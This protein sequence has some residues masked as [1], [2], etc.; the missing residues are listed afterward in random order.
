MLFPLALLAALHAA[1]AS[2][3]DSVT[4]TWRISG[5][6]V[7][8][9]VNEL[10]TLK[11]AG[12]AV[13]GSCK[14]ADAADAKPY[15]VTGEVKGDTVTFR[16]GGDYQGTAITLTYTGTTATPKA[17]KGTIDVQPFGVNGT[18]SAAPAPAAPAK[19]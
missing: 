7:G 6:V 16:H 13:T 3:A 1:P 19:P 15:D 12:A 11:Q 8:N 10:C 5:D 14:N 9:P 18:F 2:A 4:G 17:L